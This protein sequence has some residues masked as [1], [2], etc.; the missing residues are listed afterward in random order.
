MCIQ[1]M[2]TV[3]FFVSFL[4]NWLLQKAYE[5]EHEHKNHSIE[6]LST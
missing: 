5:P 4:E 6:T 3:L 1:E 2:K